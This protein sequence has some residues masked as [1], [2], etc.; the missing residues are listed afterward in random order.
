[1]NY[2]PTRVLVDKLMTHYWQ[3]VHVIA[4][5][6]HRPTFER[7]Y[8]RFWRD[9]GTGIEPRNSFQAVVFAA[10]LSSV[11]S[12]SGDRIAAD[13]GVDKQGLVDNF[14]EATEAA[15]SRANLL[16]TTKLETI[17][18]FVMYLV[19]II[20]SI[21]SSRLCITL[22]PSR[23]SESHSE[24]FW[25]IPLCRAEVS[26]AHSALTGT[27]IRLAECM[28]LHKDPSAY[29]T[30]P[31]ECQV[32]RLIWHQI[33][34]L[35][36]RTCEATGP[37]PQI[38]PDDFDTN[39][40]LN[41]D[42]ID[43]D[44]AEHGDNSVDVQ[45]DRKHFTDMTITR[46]RFECY[47]MHRFLWVERPK[48]QRNRKEGEKK[49]TINSLLA[50][51]QSFRAAIEKTYL[52]MLSK[53]VPLHALASQIYG[54]LSNRLYI[55]I[56]QKFLSSSR[57]P[58]PDRLRQIVLS[59][60]IMILE[61]SQNIEE[62][63]ALAT[64][65]WYVGALHQYHTALLLINELYAQPYT[66][67]MEQRAWR[68]LDFVFEL[69]P[70]AS[71]TQKTRAVLEEL[72]NKTQVYASLK[73]WRAPKDMPQ[74][75]PRTK[76]PGYQRQQKIAEEQARTRSLSSS[77]EGNIS[78]ATTQSSPPLQEPVLRPSRLPHSQSQGSGS[79]AFTG[80]IPNADWGTFDMP[81]PTSITGFQQ[82]LTSPDMF[83]TL[84]QPLNT[85]SD[86]L[87]PAPHVRAQSSEFTSFIPPSGTAG[88]SPLD[89]LNEI[90][91]VRLC[92]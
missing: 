72:R 21:C 46:M 76:T 28:G 82:P 58:M 91:W 11:I 1:M 56:L 44:R 8:E 16:R 64:W 32:R 70:D 39:L 67:A 24:D 86:N 3:A 50:R 71:P 33:C 88:S 65:S 30:S 36:L 34:F 60:A 74:A 89:A 43:L 4:R 35:D 20:T 2:L 14:R 51:I 7:Q 9:V 80:A 54:I 12:L 84:G 62:Q 40:P 75:E 47:D 37:R 85:P 55:H 45:K 69:S 63:P 57:H 38:R 78:P 5:T 6:V 49:V 17:Q 13:F 42:D 18:A 22:I 73:R 15:L 19:S 61:H 68:V 53:T 10:L 52:P 25:Q 59:A 26:R 77:A 27:C 81:L 31:I 66:P 23:S 87:M 79:G 41:I 90:D 48:L 29:S 83:S 92:S